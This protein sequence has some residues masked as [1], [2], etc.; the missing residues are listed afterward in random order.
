MSA[1]V[2]V[3][4]L[5]SS[6]KYEGCDEV[7]IGGKYRHYKGNEYVVLGVA[8]HSENPVQ[9]MVYYRAL[10]GDCEEWVRPKEMFLE[11][12]DRPGGDGFMTTPRF[13]FL[14]DYE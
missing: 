10:H 7:I 12:V 1:D 3:F 6:V 13:Q 9:E 2:D 5:P 11:V 8:K 4:E 14:S